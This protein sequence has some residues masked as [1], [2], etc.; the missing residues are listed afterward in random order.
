MTGKASQ[1]DLYRK[2]KAGFAYFREW[3]LSQP[4]QDMSL[5]ATLEWNRKTLEAAA[6]VG[7]IAEPSLEDKADRVRRLHKAL[8][9]LTR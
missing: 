1:A 2:R 7:P 5:E 4:V 6:R 9:R 3:E 8:A